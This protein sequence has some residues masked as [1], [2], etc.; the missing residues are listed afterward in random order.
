M[1]YFII[2]QKLVLFVRT[3]KI[4]IVDRIDVLLQ[5][6]RLAKKYVLYLYNYIQEHALDT[7]IWR[8][9]GSRI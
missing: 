8:V 4:E 1:S 5:E 6:S 2:Y 7:G 3:L 9:L